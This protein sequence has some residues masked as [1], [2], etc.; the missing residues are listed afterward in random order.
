M[1]LQQRISAFDRL[2]DFLRNINSEN[3]DYK[4]LFDTV[5]RAKDNNG[6]FSK[7]NVIYALN[8]WGNLLNKK[9]L[10]QWTKDYIFENE[11][12]KI[13]GLVLAGNI[14]LVG[15]H[16]VLSVLISGNKVLVKCS[17]SDPL[18]ISLL[19]QKL[20]EIEPIFKDLVEFTKERFTHFDAVIATGSNNAAR[21]FEYYFSKVPNLIRAN[22]NSVAVLDGNETKEQLEALAQDVVRYFGLGCRSTS[23]VFVPVGYDLNLIFGALYPFESLM[24]SAKYAN[25]YDYNKAVYLMS[26][27]DLLDNG[28]FMLKEDESYTSPVACLHYE[29]YSDYKDLE[30]KL[31]LDQDLIQCITSNQKGKSHFE[32]G[33][34]QQPNLWDYADGKNT[35]HFLNILT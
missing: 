24:D 21:Y 28:F 17:S 26:Q 27:F 8:A 7:E 5:S 31:K 6:W 18:L 29:Y 10:I 14:P 3:S 20:Q 23:K 30:G 11:E 15:F 33:K 2:G 13:V 34:A 9:D 22:R 16:D 19:V 35:L 4:S 32:F 12:P 25:N 1:Q